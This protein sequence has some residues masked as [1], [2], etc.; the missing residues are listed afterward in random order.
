MKNN[1][2]TSIGPEMIEELYVLVQWPFVQDFMGYDWFHQEC[3]LYQAHDGQP[4]LDSAYFVPV[5]RIMAVKQP[6]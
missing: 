3:F 2:S 6:G 5:S 4:H 1:L